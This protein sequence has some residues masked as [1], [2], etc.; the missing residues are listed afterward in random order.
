MRPLAADDIRGTWATV[1]LPIRDDDGIDYSLLTDQIDRLIAAGVD[2]VYSNGTAG[3]MDNQTEAE[4]DYISELLADRC[5]R[6]RMPFQ[7]G[8]GHPSPRVSLERLRRAVSLAP[9]AV[10][11]ILPDWFPPHLDECADFLQRMAETAEPIPLVLYNPPHAK[12]VLTPA[13]TG[14]LARAVPTLVGVKVADGGA[15]WYGQMRAHCAALS[16]FVPGHHLATGL[17]HGAHGSYS[18]VACLNPVAARQWWR[19]MHDDP[20]G[21]LELQSRIEGFLER[22]I[23]PFAARGYSNMALD[24]MLAAIGGWCP[25]GTRLRWP[26]RGIPPTAVE[27]LRDAACRCL[28]EFFAAEGV[29]KR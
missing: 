29:C 21:A 17:L 10:Q 28:P 27:P 6:A 11:V 22:H 15:D 12:R 20:E 18:N 14:T 13:Q 23:L 26:Y 25:I 2:G 19:Q 3:E 24:K 1:L 5:E 8:V 16:I 9:G 7:L 4:F